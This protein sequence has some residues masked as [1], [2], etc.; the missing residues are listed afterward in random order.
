MKNAV[1]AWI[2]MLV[3][4]SCVSG[5]VYTPAHAPD[6]LDSAIR[7]VTSYLNANIPEGSKI[8]ILN[9]QSDSIIL[10]DYIIEELTAHAVNDRIFTVVD[11]E[12]LDVIRAEQN[13][14]LSGEVDDNTALS[15]GRFLGA[16]TI[17]TGRVS[18]VVEHYR[19][20]I[21]A[22]DVQTA[23]IQGQYNRN[24]AA[25]RTINA[26]ITRGG[27]ITAVPGGSHADGKQ[28]AE[29][30][31]QETAREAYLWTLGASVGTSFAAPWVIGTVHGTIAPFRNSF[32]EVGM[33]FGFASGDADADYYSL[34][35]FVHYAYYKP[36]RKSGGW[37]AGGGGGFMVSR[38]SFPEGD[39]ALNYP[40][41]AITTGV[42]LLNMLDISWTLRTNFV[43]TG[44][45]L[46]VGFVY[47][48]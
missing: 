14:Q 15:I 2:C 12:Q 39:A 38:Y 24:I 7:D 48:F 29:V 13:F 36:F 5:P 19:L 47:R 16:Q 20:S 45:K 22:L 28:T 33:D 1:F 27:G 10:S 6:E 30:P 9:I 17:V 8:V 35:P 41:A 18:T 11:R 4:A 37:Y 43:N 26:L 3:F 44:N 42:N 46:A 40:V 34:Y 23:Q 31:K 25:G 21:R 32:F